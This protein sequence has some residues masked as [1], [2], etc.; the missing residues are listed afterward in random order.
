M[1]WLSFCGSIYALCQAIRQGIPLLQG[2]YLPDKELQ[3]NTPTILQ[4]ITR[5]FP[6]SIVR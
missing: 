5:H 3:V 4:G 1:S 2:V 6:Y